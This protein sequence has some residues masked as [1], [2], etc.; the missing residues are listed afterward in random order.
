MLC[1]FSLIDVSPGL[2]AEITAILLIR[3]L[4]V[5]VCGQFCSNPEGSRACLKYPVVLLLA[6]HLK[7][8]SLLPTRVDSISLE[9]LIQLETIEY[10]DS[11]YSYDSENHAN[12]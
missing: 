6:S 5:S 3:I 1:R 9:R 4:D 7:K 12:R 2:A 8:I 10:R 11:P